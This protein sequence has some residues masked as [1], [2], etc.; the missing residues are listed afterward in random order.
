MTA[1]GRSDVGTIPLDEARSMMF[2]QYFR[3]GLTAKV[4]AC[5]LKVG[6]CRW[7]SAEGDFMVISL[8]VART[9]LGPI[10]ARRQL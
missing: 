3:G 2:W 4:L 8:G 1:P 5:R 7:I 10:E 9:G 6:P